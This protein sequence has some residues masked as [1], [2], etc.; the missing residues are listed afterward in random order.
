MAGT[1]PASFVCAWVMP[2]RQDRSWARGHV[3]WPLGRVRIGAGILELSI[4][5]RVGALLATVSRVGPRPYRLP[6]SIPLEQVRGVRTRSSLRW[7]AI[8]RLEITGTPW[9]GAGIYVRR[10]DLQPLLDAIEAGGARLR[11][12]PTRTEED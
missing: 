9:D 2:Y 10:P 3:S 8:V 7:F 11:S 12:A 4:R 1:E 6:I 5:G